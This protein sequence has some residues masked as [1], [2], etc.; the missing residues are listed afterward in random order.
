MI[1]MIQNDC[2]YLLCGGRF[3]TCE[4][5]TQDPDKSGLT[6]KH[7]SWFFNLI[8]KQANKQYYTCSK[9]L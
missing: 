2:I 6:L 8:S 5:Q 4:P 3:Y 9:Y 1:Q 7:Y